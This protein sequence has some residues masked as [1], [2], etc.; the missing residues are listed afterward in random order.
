MK[1]PLVSVAASLKCGVELEPAKGGAR[2]QGC[3]QF[4]PLFTIRTL[5]SIA[6]L[7]HTNGTVLSRRFGGGF[8]LKLALLQASGILPQ[9][10]LP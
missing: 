1:S 9:T 2:K 4:T 10:L 7:A 8:G 6:T 5:D 3:A